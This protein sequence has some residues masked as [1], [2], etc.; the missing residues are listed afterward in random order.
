MAID[1]VQEEEARKLDIVQVMDTN[2]DYNDNENNLSLK[3]KKKPLTA[4]ETTI[5]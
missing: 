3:R 2:D 1:V 5:T 4:T